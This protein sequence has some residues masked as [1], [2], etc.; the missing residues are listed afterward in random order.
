MKRSDKT[1]DG[2]SLIEEMLMWPNTLL[3]AETLEQERENV[4]SFSL[5]TNAEIVARL[6]KLEKTIESLTQMVASL[7]QL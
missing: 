3:T 2:D 4:E 6:I 5:P 1:P 7:R